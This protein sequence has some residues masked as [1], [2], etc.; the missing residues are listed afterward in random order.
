MGNA[1]SLHLQKFWK[2]SV[3]ATFDGNAVAM[4]LQKFW[5]LSVESNVS[6]PM[7]FVA[8]AEVL[9]CFGW[10]DVSI[11]LNVVF[12]ENLLSCLRRTRHERKSTK[13][14]SKIEKNPSRIDSKLT[15]NRRWASSG[16]QGRFRDA[17]GRAWDGFSTPKCRPKADLGA[18]RA[19]QER[20]GA[21]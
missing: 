9:Y 20:P 11:P 16:A 10:I 15:K 12:F 7:D 14:K 19:S 1:A 17:S 18:P 4:H 21:V 13:N 8:L 3:V 5:I 6:M 2:D